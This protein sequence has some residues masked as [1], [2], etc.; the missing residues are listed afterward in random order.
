MFNNYIHDLKL[1]TFDHYKSHYLICCH[2][3]RCQ[4]SLQQS[5]MYPQISAQDSMH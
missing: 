2:E 3:Y 4:L 1:F 5:L